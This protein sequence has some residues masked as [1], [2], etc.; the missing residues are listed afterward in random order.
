MNSAI[1]SFRTGKDWISEAREPGSP[2][3]PETGVSWHESDW[4]TREW[5]LLLTFLT[6]GGE[7]GIESLSWAAHYATN[8]YVAVSSNLDHW[9]DWIS[10]WTNWIRPRGNA[11][12]SI[13]PYP[14]QNPK[15]WMRSRPKHS[16]CFVGQAF[17]SVPWRGIAFRPISL[18]GDV[19]GPAGNQIN[20]PLGRGH[21]LLGW[22]S[23]PAPLIR[24]FD[25]LQ[26][27]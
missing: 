19:I 5:V 12:I 9:K 17:D 21:L 7:S 13:K 3:L 26:A 15:G 27:W 11:Y 24:N 16:P 25:W 20:P 6:Y 1:S 23:F 22:G 2:S 10:N 14:R 4:L 18:D 8:S